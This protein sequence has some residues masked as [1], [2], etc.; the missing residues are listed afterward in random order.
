MD[1]LKFDVGQYHLTNK[2]NMIEPAFL[3]LSF[4]TKQKTSHRMY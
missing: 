4:C 2:T 3:L 1:E